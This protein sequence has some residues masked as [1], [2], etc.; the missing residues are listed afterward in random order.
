MICYLKDTQYTKAGF[1]M[2]AT[3]DCISISF[4]ELPFLKNIITRQSNRRR[5]TK[6]RLSYLRNTLQNCNSTKELK[7]IATD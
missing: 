6:K 3:G 2:A 5:N 1:S 7:R 4:K